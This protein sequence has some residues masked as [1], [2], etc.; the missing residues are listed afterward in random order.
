MPQLPERAVRDFADTYVASRADL[1]PMLAT[2][3]GLDSG[4]QGL[5]DLSPAGYQAQDELARRT[6]AELSRLT[7]AAPLATGAERRCAR[8]LR[9]RLET[10]LAVSA[11]GEQLRAVRTILGPVQELRMMFTMMPAGSEAD[12]SAI[13]KRMALVPQALAGYAASLREGMARGLLAPSRQVVA[14][15]AQLQDWGT[16]GDGR[17]W[18]AQFC[19]AAQVPQ[20]LRAEL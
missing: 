16:A 5:P 20:S 8:L 10:A 17:G 18:F 12:W 11:T 9:E 4:A 3:L 19:A 1:D 14:F 2:M 7:R 6:L 13:A 15:T